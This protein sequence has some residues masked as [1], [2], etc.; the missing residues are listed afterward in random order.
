MFFQIL[1][2]SCLNCH[3]L[4]APE[5]QLYLALYQFQAL[6]H[7]L[8]SAVEELAE[9]VT[10]SSEEVVKGSDHLATIKRKLGN[11]FQEAVEG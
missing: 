2:G 6:D 3:R 1:R 8:V 9:V 10:D 7:S 5:S 4:L 11:K